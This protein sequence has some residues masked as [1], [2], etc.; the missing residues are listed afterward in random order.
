MFNSFPPLLP[1]PACSPACL[2]PPPSLSYTQGELASETH[3]HTRARTDTHTHTQARRLHEW[4]AGAN[5]KSP[6]KPRLEQGCTT[7]PGGATQVMSPSSRGRSPSSPLTR[8][9]CV[10]VFPYLLPPLLWAAFSI[11]SSHFLSGIPH[12]QYFSRIPFSPFLPASSQPFGN[13]LLPC[14]YFSLLPSLL[15][16]VLISSPRSCLLVCCVA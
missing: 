16:F 11:S 14:R 6:G 13:F 8:L 1:L 4:E 2:R 10:H 9:C 5:P 3:S 15:S 7:A 12:A